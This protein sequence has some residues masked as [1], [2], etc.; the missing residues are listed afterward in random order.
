MSRYPDRSA[1]GGP[2]LPRL[3][4]AVPVPADVGAAV[5]DV[6][7]EARRC[8]RRRGPA[9]PLGP[10]RGAARH[11]PV[12]RA[13]A[14]EQGGRG[15]GRSRP[16]CVGIAPFDVRLAG[17]G[18]FPT[19]DRPRALWL[20]IVDGAD[21]LGR[22]AAAFEAEL[23]VGRLAGGTAALPSAHDRRAHRWRSRGS[24][25]RQLPSS[26]PRRPSTPD[27]EPTASSCTGVTSAPD[28]PS[29]SRST[30]RPWTDA[31]CCV[32]HVPPS[33]AALLRS[34][35]P[36]RPPRDTT[37][38]PRDRVTGRQRIRLVVALG[39]VNFVLAAVAF[40]LAGTM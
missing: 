9:D 10:A 31:S 30:R 24:R 4:V 29:T 11:A 28:P 13:N 25:R 21:E 12:P 7:D 18:S 3:F 39:T 22:I 27:S 6:I 33:P 16:G 26:G 19:P 32:A 36:E 38:E 1:G 5:G 20:G 17:A 40:A 8:A 2:D 35:D 15:C 14:V 23:E 37:K 34:T